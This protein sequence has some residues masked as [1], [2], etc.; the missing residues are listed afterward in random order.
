MA[1]FGLVGS[2]W[3]FKIGVRIYAG[4]A[5]TLLLLSAVGVIGVQGLKRSQEE[6]VGYARVAAEASQ[7]L[8]IGGEATEIRR[9]ARGYFYTDSQKELSSIRE[10]MGGLRKKLDET[11]KITENADRLKS[12]QIISTNYDKYLA[13]VD[14]LVEGRT[15]RNKTVAEQ[16]DPLGLSIRN[17]LDGLR[18][19]AQRSGANAF[20]QQ[21]ASAERAFLKAQIGISRFV[22]GH[23]LSLAEDIRASTQQAIKAVADLAHVA[24]DAAEQALASDLSKM[25][26]AYGA[27]LDRCIALQSEVDGFFQGDFAV[28]GQLMGKSAV[29][30]EQSASRELAS[31]SESTAN[32]I[33]TSI[34][35][36]IILSVT[37]LLTGILL[38]WLIARSIIRPI[39][40]MTGTMQ[41]LSEGD[42]TVIVPALTNRDEIGDMGRAV[43]VFKDNAIRMEQMQ[44]EQEAAEKRVAAERRQA[45]LGMADDFEMQVKHVVRAVAAQA[46]ELQ[47]TAGSLSATSEEASSRSTMV[48]AAAEQASTNV[49]TVAAAAEELSSSIG[50]ISRQVSRSAEM[51]Q[52]AVSE[53]HHT[54]EIIGGLATAA[55]KIGDVVNLITDIASQTNLLALNATIE[56]AR[57]GEAG[58]GF[59]VVANE[60]KSLANQTARATEEIGQQVGDIQAATREAVKA[61]GDITGSITSINEVATVIASAVEEQGAATQEIARNEQ[62]AAAGTRDVTMNIGGVQHAAGEAGHGAGEVLD[63]ARDLSKQT[64]SLNNQVDGFIQNIRAG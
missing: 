58:K 57:A 38:A 64:E 23:D 45:L 21:V 51:S 7:A 39:E 30:I 19:T 50:E 9:L 26:E 5:L 56:A 47:A 49:Q 34:R 52:A 54:N 24:P 12:L 42:K 14:S 22:A 32:A 13:G 60:V 33:V 20:V 35:W 4:F 48:A 31:L 55:Q 8:A 40:D 43:Q 44:A 37:A 25:S 53:A 27:N 17:N 28:T 11:L 46:S 16:L 18:E 6:Y 29:D 63:A 41:R 61:I 15:R 2:V 59:A 1:S 10:K 3:Q 62:Q 36:S